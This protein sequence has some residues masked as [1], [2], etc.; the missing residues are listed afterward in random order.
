M[1]V[2]VAAV[3]GLTAGIVLNLVSQPRI[4]MSL[5]RD[6]LLPS[7]FGTINERTGTPLIATLFAMLIASVLGAF[8][9]FGT[10]VGM[11]SLGLLC[12]YAAVCLAHVALYIRHATNTTVL[13]VPLPA[14]LI[15]FIAASLSVGVA[16]R[17]GPFG[18]ITP[19]LVLTSFLSSCALWVGLRDTDV[20]AKS[21]DADVFVV[22]GG[23]AV[24]LTGAAVN[25]FMM[26]QLD[27]VW[28]PV[29]GWLGLGVAIYFSY[30]IFHSRFSG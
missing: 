23:V 9:S 8:F 18:V 17:Y 14:V 27:L 11:V 16:H 19:L 4:W 24:S 10:L 28:G 1:I 12:A 25:I 3:I 20:S 2:T 21:A 29:L 7:S 26:A 5:A 30:G 22:P 15:L 13:S 6:G